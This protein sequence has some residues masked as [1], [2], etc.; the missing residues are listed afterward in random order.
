M[1][2]CAR[3][4]DTKKKQIEFFGAKAEQSF[5]KIEVSIPAALSAFAANRLAALE[6]LTQHL[7]MRAPLAARI[8]F[9]TAH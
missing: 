6:T 8:D 4:R 5:V 9:L 7:R 2:S 3:R 1:I